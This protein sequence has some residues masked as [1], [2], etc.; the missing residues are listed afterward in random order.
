MKR[1][2]LGQRVLVN[3]VDANI[4]T[5]YFG[6]PR[7]GVVTRLRR[8]DNGAW[9]ALDKREPDSNVH[10]FPAD[11]ATRSTHVLAFPEYCAELGKVGG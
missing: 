1:F 4:G 3:A 5:M 11:D 10:P 8:A 9:V 2:Q 6:E 7:P